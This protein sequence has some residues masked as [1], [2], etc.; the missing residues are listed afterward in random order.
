MS[1]SA[2]YAEENASNPLA[3]VNSTDL[4]YQYFDLGGAD[5]QDAFI[6]GSYMLRPNLKFKYELH[7][8]STDVTGGRENGFEKVNAKLIYFPS[9]RSLND[10]W[11]VKTAVGLEWI[12]DLGDTAKG[13]GTESDQVAPLVG[14]AFSNKATGLTLL[15]LVQHFESYNGP[16]DV[17]QTALRLIAIQPFAKDWWVKGDLKVPYDWENE[18]WPAS[19]E[20]Q[21]GYNVNDG[22]AIYADVLIGIGSDR[23]YDQGIGLGLRFNY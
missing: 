3:A 14:A 18:T 15:P 9:A 6:D 8:N 11:A 4:R 19:A 22:T 2:A 20:L 7:Y 13:I 21:V 16:T 5:K 23:T 17:S 1:M 12:I 10:T